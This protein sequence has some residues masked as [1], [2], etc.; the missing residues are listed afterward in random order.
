MKHQKILATVP[1]QSCVLCHKNLTSNIKLE[2]EIYIPGHQAA[3][4]LRY[5]KT[6][7]SPESVQETLQSIIK[8]AGN[9]KFALLLLLQDKEFFHGLYE[10]CEAERN[11]AIFMKMNL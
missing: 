4:I 10:F 3:H 2:G 1:D 7:F 8:Q 6:N 9:N 11:V 5:L